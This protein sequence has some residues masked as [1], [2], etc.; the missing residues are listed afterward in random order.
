MTD[1]VAFL[2]GRGSDGVGFVGFGDDDLV[3]NAIAALLTYHWTHL[4]DS[5]REILST[6]RGREQKRK[7][8]AA[9]LGISQQNLSNRAQAAGW[10]EYSAGMQAWRELL[11][12]HTRRPPDGLRSSRHVPNNA[13]VF[14]LKPA[15][16]GSQPHN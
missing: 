8:V 2:G 9:Q 1:R 14:A 3:L 6:L 15:T 7:D 16:Q 4:E 13:I 12:R 5:Q 10:R 11:G